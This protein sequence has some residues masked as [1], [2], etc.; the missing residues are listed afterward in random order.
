[1]YGVLLN[2]SAALF[3]PS[4]N[5]RCRCARAR[6]DHHRTYDTNFHV[7]V[8]KWSTTTSVQYH[9]SF[10]LDLLSRG[11]QYKYLRE[12]AAP[13]DVIAAKESRT[14]PYQTTVQSNNIGTIVQS[15]GIS[16]Y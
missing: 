15:T 4:K 9:T 5:R 14:N 7:Q 6:A 13:I 8:R 10:L 12:D 16:T 3:T 2:R 11:V 1:M